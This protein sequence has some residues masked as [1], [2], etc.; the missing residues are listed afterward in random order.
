MGKIH[1]SSSS[2]HQELAK[3]SAAYFFGLINLAARAEAQALAVLSSGLAREGNYS[4]AVEAR[5]KLEDL[6]GR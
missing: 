5:S 4:T 3:P 1:S 2:H 6:I